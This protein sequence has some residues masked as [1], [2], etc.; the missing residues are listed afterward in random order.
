MQ[1]CNYIKIGTADAV[2]LT[3]HMNICSKMPGIP[4]FSTLAAEVAGLQSSID[5]FSAKLTEALG[6]GRAKIAAKNSSKLEVDIKSRAL[7]DAINRIGKNNLPL[8]LETGYPVSE[9]NGG[10]VLLEPLKRLRLLHGKSLG[11]IIARASAGGGT[12]FVLMEWGY[13]ETAESVTAWQ[14]CPDTKRTCTISGLTSGQRI[15]VRAISV[16]RRGQRLLSLPVG[17]LVL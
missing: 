7:C 4:A 16:G 15:W 1:K 2:Y 14:P 5:D 3:R 13:G 11:E 17:I 8:L 12:A 10:P 6:G 9:G